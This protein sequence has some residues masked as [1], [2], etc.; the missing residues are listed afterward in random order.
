MGTNDEE[1]SLRHRS[2]IEL[3]QRARR[4]S[5][6]SLEIDQDQNSRLHVKPDLN[7]VDQRVDIQA[8]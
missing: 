3:G 8:I 2:A 1:A 5:V 6:E 7:V 4:S